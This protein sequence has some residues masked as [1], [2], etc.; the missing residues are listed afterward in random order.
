M[1]QNRIIS[2]KE[3]GF[4]SHSELARHIG[5]TP[6]TVIRRF[7]NMGSCPKTYRS[8]LRTDFWTQVQLAAASKGVYFDILPMLVSS[9][10]SNDTTIVTLDDM[11]N[12]EYYADTTDNILLGKALMDKASNMLSDRAFGILHAYT[13]GVTLQ[14]VGDE[15]NLTK[16]RVRQILLKCGRILRGGLGLSTISNAIDANWW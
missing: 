6:A 5:V 8:N 13:T 10:Q 2:V 11:Y 4:E 16:E 15:Y 7:N 14:Q 3:L 1:E 12:E 9:Q